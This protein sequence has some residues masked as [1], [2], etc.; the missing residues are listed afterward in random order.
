[1]L[2]KLIQAMRIIMSFYFRFDWIEFVV[3][4]A[5][6]CPLLSDSCPIISYYELIALLRSL[7]RQNNCSDL[8]VLTSPRSG[9]LLIIIEIIGADRVQIQGF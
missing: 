1:M 8:K 7:L 2:G 5:Q 6:C 3:G 9:K 4:L